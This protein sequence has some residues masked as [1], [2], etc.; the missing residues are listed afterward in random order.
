[1]NQMMQW[2]SEIPW[3][4]VIPLVIGGI[5]GIICLA[6]IFTQQKSKVI[7]WLVW[8]ASEAQ[9]ELGEHTGQLK[10]HTVYAWFC[11]QFPIVAAVLPFSV[12][13]SWVD[14]A[15]STV[16]DWLNSGSPIGNYIRNE[17]NT[18]EAD[19]DGDVH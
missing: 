9:K 17:I 13:S 16:K 8:A 15:L 5:I 18:K 14:V 11:K 19:S 6:Y 2:V 12:F 3:E 4:Q 10:L 7:K 1:M